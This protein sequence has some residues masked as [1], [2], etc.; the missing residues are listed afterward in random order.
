MLPINTY[1][2]HKT[3]RNNQDSGNLDPM[4]THLNTLRALALST[5]A[6]FTTASTILA[7]DTI[8]PRV[9]SG[10]QEFDT[11]LLGPL[12]PEDQNPNRVD[13]NKVETFVGEWFVD[14]KETSNCESTEKDEDEVE[15]TKWT[16]LTL[17]REKDRVCISFLLDFID[18]RIDTFL[19]SEKV[20]IEPAPGDNPLRCLMTFKDG[21]GTVLLKIIARAFCLT[22][23]EEVKPEEIDNGGAGPGPKAIS[24]SKK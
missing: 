5:L 12:Q 13:A 11:E 1:S 6:L 2:V 24:D 16:I 19:S 7:N 10:E 22:L 15:K 4:K 8:V 18:G 20:I 9:E 3:P 17:Q 21:E 23:R 14:K